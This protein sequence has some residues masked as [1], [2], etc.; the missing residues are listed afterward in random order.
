ML[1]ICVD[2]RRIIGCMNTKGEILAECLHCKKFQDC[3]KDTPIGFAVERR[4]FFVSF[5]K[6]CSD[7]EQQKIGF[8]FNNDSQNHY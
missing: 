2:C 5:E 3:K 8:K 6:S 7:H 1:V 4:V